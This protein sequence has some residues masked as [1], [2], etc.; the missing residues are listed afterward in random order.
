[1]RREGVRMCRR[2]VQ[3][4]SAAPDT[5]GGSLH[6][7]TI[8]AHRTGAGPCFWRGSGDDHQVVFRLLYDELTEHICLAPANCARTAGGTQLRVSVSRP[9]MLPARLDWDQQLCI[10]QD[11]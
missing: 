2:N 6:I 1:M 10:P 11:P 7:P 5:Y 4:K 8:L 3:K 9:H